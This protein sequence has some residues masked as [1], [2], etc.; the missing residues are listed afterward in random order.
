MCYVWQ[1]EGLGKK[2]GGFRG[3]CLLLWTS[4]SFCAPSAL[5]IASTC[6]KAY[7][8]AESIGSCRNLTRSFAV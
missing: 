2:N 5:L 7:I 4:N 1:S 6:Q 3:N 8:Q